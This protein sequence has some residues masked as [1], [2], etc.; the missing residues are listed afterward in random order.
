MRF[1]SIRA[2]EGENLPADTEYENREIVNSGSPALFDEIADSSVVDDEPKLRRGWKE[3]R[4]TEFD[5]AEVLQGSCGRDNGDF[6]YV[7]RYCRIPVYI[8]MT[9]DTINNRIWHHIK[10]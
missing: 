6:I 9:R 3:I 4:Q 10:E 7:V 8:G 5:L 1:L 2:A